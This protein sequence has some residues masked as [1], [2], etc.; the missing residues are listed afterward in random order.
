MLLHDF[1]Y[2]LSS[3]Y[4]GRA[5]RKEGMEV[6]QLLRRGINYRDVLRIF[7]KPVIQYTPKFTMRREH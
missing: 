5:V 2:I 1:Q 4:I 7:R 6:R 3:T